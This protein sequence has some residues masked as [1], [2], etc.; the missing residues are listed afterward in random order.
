M[1][2]LDKEARKLSN[3]QAYVINY[4]TP[5]QIA[6]RETWIRDAIVFR[7]FDSYRITLVKGGSGPVRTVM[8]LVPPGAEN[9]TP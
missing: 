4:G 6:Q 3:D 7:R 9:P 2:D 5:A 1:V 8:W